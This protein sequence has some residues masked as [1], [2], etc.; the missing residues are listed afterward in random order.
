[1]SVTIALAV[2]PKSIKLYG[3]YVTRGGEK[4]NNRPE[5]KW[6]YLNNYRLREG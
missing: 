4:I 2:I 6:I 3:A 5:Y 1:M